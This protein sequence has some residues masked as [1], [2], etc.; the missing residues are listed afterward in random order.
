MVLNGMEQYDE[1]RAM[2][3]L[4]Q[5][6][7]ILKQ[8]SFL[9]MKYISRDTK[10]SAQ[11]LAIWATPLLMVLSVNVLHFHQQYGVTG[12]LDHWL[13]DRLLMFFYF[14]LLSLALSLFFMS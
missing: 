2:K 10:R 14:V 5:G 7:N 6:R 12:V 3:N 4:M 1:W 11:N 9:S 8:H 13:S